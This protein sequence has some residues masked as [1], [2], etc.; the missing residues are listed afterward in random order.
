MDAFISALVTQVPDLAALIL[1]VIIF[2]NRL[3]AIEEAHSAAIKALQESNSQYL[4]RRDEIY[5]ST[6]K[7]IGDQVTNLTEAHREH[8]QETRDAVNEMHR[9]IAARKRTKVAH[10]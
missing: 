3:Q 8:A 6:V 9:T 4:Q 7:Q 5:I 1:V 2:L 10:D